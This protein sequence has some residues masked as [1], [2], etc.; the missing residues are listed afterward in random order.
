MEYNIEQIEKRNE[1]NKRRRQI[2]KNV[3]FVV[4]VILLYNIFLI[5]KSTLDQTNAKTIFGYKA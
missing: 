4:I 1:K 3:L 2:I 5:T